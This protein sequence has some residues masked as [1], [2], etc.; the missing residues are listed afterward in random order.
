M[1]TAELYT[2]GAQV[3]VPHPE[4]VWQGAELTKDYKPGD[5]E[6]HLET[7]EERET[8]VKK[9]KSD[10]DL[11]PLRN[12]DILVGQNDLTS[13]SY[14]HEPAVLYNLQVRFLQNNAIYTYCG[15]VLV[16]INP[17]EQLPLYGNEMVMAYT[18]QDMGAMDPH[19]YAVAEEAFRQMQRDERNQ[20]IIV[21]G[22]SGAGKTV[23]AKYAMRYF[24]TVGGSS[25]DMEASIEQRVLASNPIMET[26][27]SQ[28][29]SVGE[30][31]AETAIE[32]K[33]LASNP[34]MEAIGN[35]K[36]IRN[37]NSS[38]FGKYI[39]IGF[40][41]NYT[42][43]G[44]NMRTYLLEKSRIVFQAENERTY[45]IFYQLCAAA[46]LPEFEDFCLSD[47]MNFNYT[48]Q[49]GDPVIKDLDDLEEF[50]NTKQAMSLLGFSDK[51]QQ[52]IFR[53]LAALLHLGNIEVDENFKDSEKC[54]I[55]P[56]NPHLYAV[57]ELLG[58]DMN[59]FRKWM[60]NRKIT[61]VHQVIEK[62]LRSSEAMH[63]RDALAKFLYGQLFDWIVSKINTV[64]TPQAKEN[65]FI[66]VLDIYGFEVF[67]VNSFEQFC[68]NYANEKLQQ[69]FTQHVFKLEQEEYV[70]EEITWSFI[71]YYDN[72]PCIDLIEAKLGLLDLLDEECKLPKGS[73]QNWCQKLYDK[74]LKKA[75]HF[76]K[77]RMSNSAFII[78]HFADKVE[79]Q[80]E[81]FL[82][83]NRDLV[84]E[85]HINILRA[86]EFQLVAD[87][88]STK[89]GLPAPPPAK[90]GKITMK[91]LP[92]KHKQPSKEMRK[93]VGLQFK[94]SLCLLME[95]L[96]S[97]TPHYVRC[98]KPN[99]EKRAFTF[100]P[101]R[102][103]QQ[104]RAC[105]V[106]ETIR[107]SSAGYPSRWTYPE[108]FQRYRVLMVSTEI[109]REDMKN[110]CATVVSRLIKDPDKFQFGKT[111][112]F[113]RAGQVAYMEKLRSDKLRAC[114]IMIQK[115]I[116]GWLMKR[117]YQ[118]L[119][120]LALW[121]QQRTRGILARR[122][123]KWMRE[124]KAATTIQKRFRGYLARSRYL[125]MRWT[126]LRIQAWGRGKFAR[127]RFLQLRYEVKA[128]LIQ[129][130]WRG[131][132]ARK[133]YW[134]EMQSII[135]IQSCWRR[136]LA[137]KEL[138][139]LKIQA[140]SVDHYK[141][142]NKGMENKIIDLQRKLNE[143]NKESKE[144]HK[145]VEVI[146][147]LQT[148]VTELKKTEEVAKVS[149]NKV[150]ELEDEITKL[151]A[152][153][154]LT[155]KEK[156]MLEEEGE[157]YKEEQEMLNTALK[158][159]IDR[160]AT[161]NKE[162]MEKV[163]L[164]EEEFQAAHVPE[165]E[166]EKQELE[167]ELAQERSQHQQ[168]IKDYARMEQRYENLRDEMT[169]LQQGKV[170]D[171]DS[172]V[173]SPRMHRRAG[174][175]VSSVD[176]NSESGY[177]TI[178]KG[179]G[180]EQ[181]SP[182]A[183]PRVKSLKKHAQELE[184]E[185][186]RLKVMVEALDE[187]KARMETMLEAETGSE[188]GILVGLQKKLEALQRENQKLAALAEGKELPKDKDEENQAEVMARLQKRLEE[189][190][191]ERKKLED[192]LEEKEKEVKEQQADLVDGGPEVRRE[193]AILQRMIE[194][195]EGDNEALL[196]DLKS[197]EKIALENEAL[198]KNITTLEADNKNL[199]ENIKAKEQSLLEKEEA[200]DQYVE[201]GGRMEYELEDFQK[202]LGEMR[203]M[204]QEE[205]VE[206]SK[207]LISKQETIDRYVARE[208]EREET[209]KLLQEQ[210]ALLTGK[211]EVMSG[212]L[213]DMEFEFK[214]TT[215][216]LEEEKRAAVN[217]LESQMEELA[218]EKD[219][220]DAVM[221]KKEREAE[222]MRQKMAQEKDSVV[223]EMQEELENIL[224]EKQKLK[225]KIEDKEQEM[226]ETA[227]KLEEEKEE[228]LARV[229]EHLEA[230]ETEKENIRREMAKKDIVMKEKLWK[231]E[232][233][234]KAL[235]AEYQDEL[236]RLT[237]DADVLDALLE[238]KNQEMVDVENKLKTEK[239][240][241]VSELQEELEAIQF[242][243]EKLKAA[244]D[245]KEV[246]MAQTA[247]KLQ[248]EKD[249]DLKKVVS[250]L[251]K[252]KEK[253]EAAVGEKESEIV[254]TKEEL[255]AEKEAALSE[256]QRQMNE[257]I[258][259][260]EKLS[261]SLSEKE[262]E[263]VES[264]QKLKAEKEEREAKLL[265]EISALR[266]QVQDMEAKYR[267]DMEQKEH[268]VKAK[269]ET[270]DSHKAQAVTQESTVHVLM[271]QIK[272]LTKRIASMED[273]IDDMEFEFQEK[274]EK[275]EGEKQ[276]A[277]TELETQLKELSGQ[278]DSMES[279]LKSKEREITEAQEKI[280]TENVGMV[281]KLQERLETMLAEKVALSQTIKKKDADMA[282]MVR[283][284]EDEKEQAINEVKEQLR[285]A[286]EE[287]E[288]LKNVLGKKEAELSERVRKM[289]EEKRSLI[290]QFQ[291]QLD[292]LSDEKDILDALLEKKEQEMVET[293]QKLEEE[294]SGTVFKLKQELNDISRE[295]EMLQAAIH[296][297][298]LSMAETSQKLGIQKES[299]V[300]EVKEQLEAVKKER[301]KW[302]K[303]LEKKER[304]MT[305]RITRLEEEK[306]NL[307]TK[308]EKEVEKL[309][310]DRDMLE[311]Q[312]EKKDA[313]MVETQRTLEEE[314]AQ[315]VRRV[316]QDLKIIIS[317]RMKLKIAIQEKEQMMADAS[318]KLKDEKEK[319]IS[320]LQTELDQRAE[321]KEKLQVALERKNSEVSKTKKQLNAEKQ[322]AIRTLKRQL[323]GIIQEKQK[324]QKVI[325]Q[326][327]KEISQSMKKIQTQDQAVISEL[328]RKVDEI[329][330]VRDKLQAANE[331]EVSNAV[332]ALEDAIS[333]M[334][335]EE[336]KEKKRLH[337]LNLQNH[338]TKLEQENKDL[339]EALDVAKMKRFDIANLPEEMSDL[340][341]E[342]KK[343]KNDI[344]NLRQAVADSNTEE[345]LVKQ[346]DVLTEELMV[347][348]EEVLTLKTSMVDQN[349][350]NSDQWDKETMT[351][352]DL[353][354]YPPE[355]LESL[356]EDGELM[357]AYL[358]QKETNRLLEA[359]MQASKKNA[360][361]QEQEL[362]NEIA[363]LKEEN[364]RQQ[365]LLGQ[366][367]DR[368]DSAWSVHY[369]PDVD[370]SNLQL[371]PEARI[372]ANLQHEI[373]RLTADNLDLREEVE[374]HDKQV[375][376]LKKQI[377]ILMKRQNM[378]GGDQSA[379]TPDAGSE[380]SP[381]E[382]EG[383]PHVKTKDDRVFMGM[384]E[385]RKEDEQ[386]LIKNL[387]ID[388]KPKSAVNM[389]PGLPAYIL[390]MC[391]RHADYIGDDN[392]VKSLL[393]GTINGIKRVLKKRNED[394][395]TVSFW[396]ANTCRL[397]HNLKQYSGEESFANQN[398]KQQN[399][400]CLRNFD[401]TE[402][403]QVLSDLAVHI[404]QMMIKIMESK[405]QPMI[406]PGMLEHEAIPGVSGGAR[407]SGMRQRTQ[408]ISDEMGG[409]Y[410]LNSILKQLSV[411]HS[412]MTTH[413]M[414]P[415]LVKQTFRQ[416]FY[417]I[418]AGTL[419]NLLL[420][421]EMCHWSKG[422]QIRYNVSQ[423]EEWCRD[424]HLSDSGAIQSLEPVIQA[425]QLLQVNKKTEEDAKAIC[426]TCKKLSSQQII[427]ILN[428][429][430]PVNE[431]E[432][433]VSISFIR[434]IQARL[435][436]RKDTQ[437]TLLLDTKFSY[438]VTF[439]F[440]PSSL[441]LDS[442]QLP[443]AL[444]VTFLR[445]V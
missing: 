278:K 288:G 22:E 64:L 342:N 417:I 172:A 270:I 431:F 70:R 351:D 115:H 430:T 276:S 312:M 8:I 311:A 435:K 170:G 93:T 11:P 221:E 438:P 203:T 404:Y 137:K 408:S 282:D 220:L 303:A 21:S 271:H 18:G 116:R 323:S 136:W 262:K 19:I 40:N 128:R 281:A 212:Y 204:F 92:Q 88:V 73:D 89:G 63:G 381:K 213:Q 97:T 1:T 100:E 145:K 386:K 140:K 289:E 352:L 147:D 77:P 327:E 3:W 142:L 226:A 383:G 375:R 427:K 285:R 127:I 331:K 153:L 243:R 238:K 356:N 366:Q 433:R 122:Y 206:K 82:E 215:T 307:A 99:D 273:K 207:Q 441:Q 196:D 164:Q 112:I 113:F 79:Y 133:R 14:L 249:R 268:E 54:Y 118:K 389:L 180:E 134:H 59:Q 234:K 193:F 372:E 407:P 157:I 81:G 412:I 259:E 7:E 131:Y 321:E 346:L 57:A 175:D 398:N 139:K 326:K 68:I 104:L 361:F 359:Q 425:A 241:A 182:K 152:E 84:N 20:S 370:H 367:T 432:E 76:D 183:P 403:R 4:L 85:E 106:L 426:D 45:H 156:Q 310:D 163:A 233:E 415:E 159:E 228:E 318:D 155:K 192:L 319:E 283:K 67:E 173:P 364:I 362:R 168:L 103:M 166:L 308:Y 240:S 244:L 35:A 124:T 91:H 420:R 443:E 402:Y 109:N 266:K 71:D 143:Q 287:Q 135:L 36:T 418:G 25:D 336:E 384:L 210:L 414:D 436:E 355:Y 445:K 292:K 357:Q 247:I 376:R 284:L 83:K 348:R 313:E 275:L 253:F 23:S 33:V 333:H 179:E 369:V 32:R 28:F 31:T 328:Q 258:G 178:G 108:F 246:A 214:E 344:S 395:E 130:A 125:K 294:K 264:V 251:E 58:V 161:E 74:H 96:N 69:Q 24:A 338:V 38:R 197:K 297:K 269:E 235:V 349:I 339:Q 237:D 293:K 340:V 2:K 399:E 160:L 322:A 94:E 290:S 62:P 61:A 227:Q 34:V 217:E 224:A 295:R 353:Y 184:G 27:W 187:E 298:E 55:D 274:T 377:K 120:Q 374:N 391:I 347:R 272:T 350:E 363:A 405:L 50:H 230:V 37:D 388:L 320:G 286:R 299:A 5:K 87:L 181:D 150:H 90:K 198:K 325:V 397:L 6:M 60:C 39:Q 373:T 48:N 371:T 232:E 211:I 242:Q 337:L 102:A 329:T 315:A 162:L 419:N 56:E 158:A 382:D 15:I 396:L 49:G 43:I 401:L 51:I 44:A 345:E 400:H 41:K 424:H 309:V 393:T 263:I 126:I 111:K 219:T 78:Y 267:E 291:D 65:S 189:V 390:F 154:D 304:D 239:S 119:K 378:Q 191:S 53:I 80:A 421:K 343:L 392:K 30:Y 360:E 410:T 330:G 317:E 252:E 225:M 117:R 411:F 114:S 121:L 148:Q 280:K 335:T 165:L 110:T 16:A 324:L 209:I 385:Y 354:L 123:L 132:V 95:T 186:Q 305:N 176:L 195:L 236:E 261:T 188:V 416:T 218:L 265:S 201:E 72:Q 256:M 171:M 167:E 17:Y 379:L 250:E 387:I 86:S 222:E 42:I 190:E 409:R 257:I 423:L 229:Q 202:S 101:K 437:S 174:S 75:K 146:Q 169:L 245:E 144:L 301:E 13:L 394:F 439:P 200:L 255:R 10:E 26:N 368:R 254:K 52:E 216:K 429:Y 277:V 334:D 29:L 422:M 107:I 314:K 444:N 296:E 205:A 279:L 47:P 98:I 231:L 332:Q 413:G 306:E 149:S 151:K 302:K 428:L 138:K 46:D 208:A 358:T 105:G 341:E 177:G 223:T 12:P 194:V 129:R 380:P 300:A 66:G 248:E 9:M 316:S 141:K 199:L 260:K 365:K 406:V 434:I 442:I 185:N 440:N